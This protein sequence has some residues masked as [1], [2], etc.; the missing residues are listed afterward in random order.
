[1]F[2][3]RA[4]L[5]KSRCSFLV[6]LQYFPSIRSSNDEKKVELL[7]LRLAR[8]GR[9]TLAEIDSASDLRVED[10]VDGLGAGHI[11]RLVGHF[12]AA[13]AIL[14]RR[15]AGS[16]VIRPAMT[17]AEIRTARTL[18]SEYTAFLEADLS[19]QDFEKEISRLPGKYA[20]PSGALFIAYVP[21]PTAAEEPA[22]CVAV[23]PLQKGFC[24]MKRLFVRPELRGFGIGRL[25][26]ITAMLKARR[27][28]FKPIPPYC[29]NPLPGA[30]SRE[31][32][33]S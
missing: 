33:L 16:P 6:D 13:E 31:K 26:A 28:G 8:A 32:A 10:F 5:I 11:G 21:S 24:E 4:V 25:L 9:R 2:V 19:F 27:M 29:P 12:K 30:M 3:G 7:L 17:P 20:S 22:G 18:M 15:T 14:E 23:R 1:M